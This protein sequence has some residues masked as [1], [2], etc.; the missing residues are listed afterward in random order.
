MNEV[1]YSIIIPTY[2]CFHFLAEC[3]GNVRRY[4]E[5]NTEII[6]VNNGS[7]DSTNEYLEKTKDI[8]TVINLDKNYGFAK[9]VNEGIKIAKG[10]WIVLLNNDVLVT[11]GWLKKLKQG[12]KTY[13][14]RTGTKEASIAVP[15]SNYVGMQAQQS[16][17]GD[18]NNFE[19]FAA[20][21][22]KDNY[23]TVIP[24]GTVSG[25]LMLINREVFDKIGLLDEQ[26]FAG[27]DD[28]DFSTRAYEA[29]F[30]SVVCKDVFV[31]HYGSRTLLGFP[32]YDVGRAQIPDLVE[33]YS[34]LRSKNQKLGVIYRVKIRDDYEADV[35]LRSLTK[36]STFAD[37]IFI[38]DDDSPLGVRQEDKKLFVGIE[39]GNAER[40]AK[41]AC[42]LTLQKHTRGFDERRDR[43]ELLLMAKKANMDWVFSLDADE[44]VEGCVD[45]K[46]IERLINTPDPSAQ[47]YA[48]HI[49][50][51]WNDEKHYNAGDVWKNMHGNRLVRLTGDPRIYAGSKST[52]H[53]GNVPY[54]PEDFSRVSPIRIKH[55]GYVH[56]K[57]RQKKYE[58]YE[59]I[60]FDKDPALI[61][62][63]DYYH[64]INENP[65]VLRSWVENSTVSLC[66]IM[67]NE[68]QRIFDFLRVYSPFVHEMV[69]VDT[70]STDKS[71]K[72]AELFGCKIVRK[73]WNDSFSDARNA[74]L[75][76]ATSDWILHLDVDESMTFTD[77]AVMRRMMD[78]S[79]KT[80]GYMFYVN[81]LMKG[82]KYSISETVRLFR[83]KYGFKYSGYVHETIERNGKIDIMRS[84]VSIYHYGYL[85]S[86]EDMKKKLQYY[87][88]MNQKQIEDFP[89]DPRPRY[90]QA[91]HYLEENFP[92]KAEEGLMK[93]I[94]LDSNFYQAH[95]DLAYLKL[96][97]AMSEFEFVARILPASHPFCGFAKQNID[98]IRGLVG[99]QSRVAPNH[100]ADLVD[101]NGDIVKNG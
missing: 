55:F 28:V 10:K 32:E 24:V 75:E 53:V 19:Q 70:G 33:K 47:A 26:F 50:T 13:Q 93:A 43:N 56:P 101:T 100:I 6:I 45:R 35:F 52:L 11:K 1:K 68:Q 67:K 29:G 46:L 97:Q 31:F 63:K 95:K 51:F 61:G 86:D 76:E 85:R 36:S 74:G 62:H 9:A 30:I 42:D 14:Q 54:V 18:R 15:V 17:G 39:E 77:L 3:L 22:Y 91:I 82:K 40:W 23:R 89:K 25:M 65:V 64:I 48:V 7:T 60:D 96:A 81:N 66:T 21:I 94:S 20:Q 84:P 71:I 69:L 12:C 49:Y 41:I 83:S 38:L 87:F 37:H 44:I 80:G 58:W 34:K 27:C 2:N 79:E 59:K 72:I 8:Y 16:P 92:E 98:A 88:K 78:V 4:S 90:A 73:E 99:E 57:Q 5:K